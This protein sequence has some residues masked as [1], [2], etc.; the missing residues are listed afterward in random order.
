[1]SLDPDTPLQPNPYGLPSNFDDP[2]TNAASA[3]VTV[4]IFLALTTVM[5]TLR[6]I[7][8]VVVLK[9]V[10][11]DDICSVLALLSC[12]AEAGCFFFR[13]FLVL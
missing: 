4:S 2:E 3:I 9:H 10:G 7:C 6:M 1:M 12:V 13:E 11:L 5:V 8:R